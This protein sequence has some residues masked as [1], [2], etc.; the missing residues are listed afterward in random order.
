M[1]DLKR[2]YNTW[3]CLALCP[4]FY[5]FLL[6][7]AAI[8]ECDFW[9]LPSWVYPSRFSLLGRF[10]VPIPI[11]FP[12]PLLFLL[13]L[14]FLKILIMEPPLFHLLAGPPTI[15]SQPGVAIWHLF[16]ALGLVSFSVS[17][18]CDIEYTDAQLFALSKF[19]WAWFADLNENKFRATW[20]SVS[21]KI[22]FGLPFL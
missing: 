14:L 3:F 17:S 20:R 1:T 13:Y 2:L 7:L 18:T 16:I 4:S 21:I 10:S 5:P 6:C 9:A 12:S 15:F 19:L 11:P 22:D 8:S